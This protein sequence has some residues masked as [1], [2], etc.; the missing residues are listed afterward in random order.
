LDDDDDQYW[1]IDG[2]ALSYKI[3]WA[4][5]P[6]KCLDV[7]DHNANNG[8]R[9]QIWDCEEGDKD[10][11]FFMG[12]TKY[13]RKGA[14][15]WHMV[16]MSKCLDVRDHGNYDGN[17]VQIWDCI[18]ADTDQ[19]W[20]MDVCDDCAKDEGYFG[21]VEF[22][23]PGDFQEA[24]ESGSSHGFNDTIFTSATEDIHSGPIINKSNIHGVPGLNS[25]AGHEYKF[26]LH[27]ENHPDKCL[28]VMD[29]GYLNGTLVQL[30][31]CLE[32]DD[33]QYFLID[34]DD[35]TISYKIRWANHP[36]KCLD[37]QHG[38][39]GQNGARLQIW[40]CKREES[41]SHQLFFMGSDSG[42]RNGKMHWHT[43]G[44]TKCV[45]IKEHGDYKGAWIQIWD[46]IDDDTD[47][48]WVMKA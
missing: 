34:P 11:L 31:E 7:K 15:H 16:G 32:D 33:D 45:D 41:D 3:R 48:N 14:L 30:W 18:D 19:D 26:K 13:N 6:E 36:E 43:V 21:K 12:S 10:Q 25:S 27:W 35:A 46:C 38:S 1:S 47:Q 44:M 24:V 39:H 37:V 8:A 23:V 40:D 22:G 17:V 5:H 2:D 20:V 28:D 42:S 4:N 9:L 29:H